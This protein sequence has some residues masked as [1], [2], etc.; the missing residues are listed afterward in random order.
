MTTDSN[1]FSENERMLYRDGY[2]LAQS[3]VEEGLT[4]KKLFEAIQSLYSAIDELNDS[5]ISYARKQNTNVACAKGCQWCC[6]QAVFANSYEIHFLSDYIGKNFSTDEITE[7]TRRIHKKHEITSKL[8]DKEVLNFKAPCPL[9]KD[10]ACSA[11]SARPVA[12]R[13][14]LSTN[15]PSCLHFYKHP[16]D[17]KNYPMLLEFPLKAGRL[18]NEGFMA[19]LKEHGVETFEF[20]IEAGL[21]RMFVE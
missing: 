11:Y 9:L 10:G 19:A 16:E 21:A 18:L 3:A 12:C 17:E 20:K 15:L 6:H 1:K 2:R 8:D 4:N 13:I 14:Y 7:L 5:I